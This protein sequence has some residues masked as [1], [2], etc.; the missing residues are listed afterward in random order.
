M[1]F[2]GEVLVFWFFLLI[3]F[4]VFSSC[5][6]LLVFVSILGCMVMI[7]LKDIKILVGCFILERIL[8]VYYI[9]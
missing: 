1:C 7:D 4:G 6:I 9:F 8:E 2:L 5:E 3:S